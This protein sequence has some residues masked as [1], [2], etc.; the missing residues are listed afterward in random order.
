MDGLP[1]VPADDMYAYNPR[2]LHRDLNN[3]A[4]ST[5]MTAEN[6]LNI[7]VGQASSSITAFQDELGGRFGDAFL[8]MHGSGHYAAGGDAS[9][10][11]S[12][13]NDPTFFLHHA[14]VDRVYWLWQSLHLNKAFEVGGTLTMFNDPPSRNA[15]TTDPLEVLLLG[16][17]ITI[18]DALS[19]TGG[20]FCY[21]YV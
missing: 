5:W 17:T 21:I 11:F 10:F 16:D 19:T 14:M 12:S 4:A 18:G 9:C 8:G 6:L 3:Y 20:S 7:T 2:C 15:T 13:T 1:A